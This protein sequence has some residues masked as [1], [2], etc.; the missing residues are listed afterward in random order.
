[1]DEPTNHLD[2]SIIHQLM[3]NLKELKHAPT[4]ILISHNLEPV[5][6]VQQVYFP[7]SGRMVAT[8]DPAVFVESREEWKRLLEQEEERARRRQGLW[9]AGVGQHRS[10]NRYCVRRSC[11][12]FLGLPSFSM[13]LE[14][15]SLLASAGLCFGECGQADTAESSNR[16]LRH[17]DPQFSPANHPIA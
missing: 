10:R 7:Q 6:E 16:A 4:T 12:S 5:R 1:L 13:S 2:Q 3:T 11:A 15:G 14:A 9:L 8:G 17:F